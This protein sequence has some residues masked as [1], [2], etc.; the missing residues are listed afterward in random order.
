M[1]AVTA[2]IKNRRKIVPFYLDCLINQDYPLDNLLFVFL[3][4]HST[5]G[6]YEYL[7]EF[8]Y[9]HPEINMDIIRNPIDLFPLNHSSRLPNEERRK[10]LYMH[11]AFLRNYM[12]D[13]CKSKK[14]ITHQF[15][16]DTDILIR[17]DC[18]SHLLKHDAPYMATI[19]FNDAHCEQRFLYEKGKML[20]RHVNFGVLIQNPDTQIIEGYANFNY[21]LDHVYEGL[22]TGACYLVNREVIDSGVYFEYHNA[23]EDISYC[24]NLYE[25]G[26][27]PA[28]DTTIK[29]VHIMEEKFLYDALLAFE[30]WPKDGDYS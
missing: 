13:Y 27:P 20:Q 25:K 21:E 14:Y 22:I 11:L 2:P 1:I 19:I 23:G 10:E 18:L 4:D 28:V 12:I 8:R 3:D 16:V 5:D 24:L 26:F 7:C 17:P 15:S 29:A 9:R 6:T 30:R